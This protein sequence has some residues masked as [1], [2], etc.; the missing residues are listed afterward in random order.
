MYLFKLDSGPVRNEVRAIK[1]L[2]NGTHPNIVQVFAIGE[3][4]DSSHVFIDMALCHYN[5]K[6]SCK[7]NWHYGAVHDY[8]PEL[9]ADRFWRIIQQIAG[10]LVFIHSNDE[11]HRDI[12]PQNG[13][14]L[15]ACGN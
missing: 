14:E 2:C 5:L 15:F 4:P 6:E 8:P 11:V 3:L 13:S 10:G 9:V 12:K 7:S 1:K